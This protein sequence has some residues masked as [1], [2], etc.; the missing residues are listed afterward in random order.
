MGCAD[1][2]KFLKEVS[3]SS[4]TCPSGSGGPQFFYEVSYSRGLK[5]GFNKSRVVDTVTSKKFQD[6]VAQTAMYSFLTAGT[7]PGEVPTLSPL[8]QSVLDGALKGSGSTCAKPSWKTIATTALFGV[9]SYC[10]FLR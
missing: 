4:I 9:V 5:L 2:T 1:F 3:A 6:L 7:L 8:Q 10:F